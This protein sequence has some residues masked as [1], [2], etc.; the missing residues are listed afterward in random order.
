MT[1]KLYSL[2]F[3]QKINVWIRLV[4]SHTVQ[5]CCSI[6]KHIDNCPI[7]VHH[8]AIFIFVYFR[9]NRLWKSTST[10]ASLSGR[11]QPSK[12]RITLSYEESQLNR[13]SHYENTPIQFIENFTS[14]HSNFSDKNSYIFH[15]STKNIDC[16][17]SLE[18]PW[19]EVLTSTTIYVSEQK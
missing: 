14:K 4:S 12:L 8:S 19:Q 6:C 9:I 18:S 5:L 10:Y 1:D 11:V 16:E 7:S 2:Y 3:V 17:Y 13:D 15:I